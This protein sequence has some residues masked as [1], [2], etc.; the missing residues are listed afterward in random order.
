M[1]LIRD[2]H[3]KNIGWYQTNSNGYIYIYSN[4]DGM[5]GWY[6]PSA[7]VT[8]DRKGQRVGYGNQLI[9]LLY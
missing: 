1:Q 4:K 6:I 3:G 8:F 7:D 5:L 2:K 9:S